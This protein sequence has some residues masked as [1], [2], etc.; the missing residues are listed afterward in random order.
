MQNKLKK[1]MWARVA[2][3]IGSSIEE[4]KFAGWDFRD[5][6]E[7]HKNFFGG[8]QKEKTMHDK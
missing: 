7:T 2:K 8:V 5:I 4:M 6:I 3:Y 1:Q